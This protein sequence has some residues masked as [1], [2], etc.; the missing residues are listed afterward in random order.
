LE[1]PYS[2]TDD[3][4]QECLSNCEYPIDL[5]ACGWEE[6]DGREKPSHFDTV[7]RCGDLKSGGGDAQ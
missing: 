1:V 2:Y 5:G 4:I 3:Q 7:V 6:M